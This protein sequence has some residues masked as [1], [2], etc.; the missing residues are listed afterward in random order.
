MY[1]FACFERCQTPYLFP[2]FVNILHILQFS[3]LNLLVN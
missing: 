2:I 1:C 3:L